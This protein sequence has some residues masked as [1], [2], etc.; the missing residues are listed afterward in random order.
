MIMRFTVLF[1]AFIISLNTI[2][3]QDYFLKNNGPYENTI[4][5]PEQYLGYEIGFEHT[6]HDLIVAYLKY[7]SNISEKAEIIKYGEAHEGRDLIMLTVS[8]AENLNNLEKIKNEHLKHTDPGIKTTI[9]SSLP[10]IINLG[11]GETLK[12]WAIPSATD[13][14]FSLG[15]LSL[16]GK[17]LPLSLKVFLTALAI[18]DDLG[19]IVII[20]LFILET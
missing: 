10:I 16:L 12:G 19:A 2:T 18:I 15:V 7:L 4:L 5:T 14:A 8:S 17:R 6:R 11:D 9:D 3:A 1:F 20:A 13:I